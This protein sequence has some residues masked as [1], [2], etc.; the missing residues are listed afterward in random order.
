MFIYLT[1]TNATQGFLGN[2]GG[3]DFQIYGNELELAL[4]VSAVIERA[5][6]HNINQWY[7]LAVTR[8]SS[9]DI[10]IFV[11]G[12]QLG[13]V[14]NSTADLRHASN[15]FHIGNIGPATSRPFQGGYMDEIRIT[16][17]ARYTSS[18]TPPTQTFSNK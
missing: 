6:T 5:W 8:D 1:S 15:D 12:T 10:R 3:W 9:N 18:F 11:D 16:R 13:A 2:D 4:G 7:H 14:V 17:A